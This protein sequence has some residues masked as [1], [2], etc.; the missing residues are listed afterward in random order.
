M[1]VKLLTGDFALFNHKWLSTNSAKESILQAST[2]YINPFPAEP[3]HTLPLQTEKIQISLLL[4]KPT[5][6]D[7]HFLSLSI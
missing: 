7:L 5:D 4:Q 1:S 3:G 2:N 6:L